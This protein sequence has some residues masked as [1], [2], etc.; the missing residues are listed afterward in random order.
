[1]GCDA[2]MTGRGAF[3]TPWM[4]RSFSPSTNLPDEITQPERLDMILRQYDYAMEYHGR[5]GGIK[6]MRKHLMSYTKGMRGGSEF[7]NS[8]VRLTDYAEIAVIVRDFFSTSSLS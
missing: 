2:V 7:R 8:I 3:E 4:F 1:T 5:D 6:M